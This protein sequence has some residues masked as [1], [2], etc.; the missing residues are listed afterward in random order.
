MCRYWF[1][2]VTLQNKPGT[3]RLQRSIGTAPH[4][5]IEVILHVMIVS[6]MTI[7]QGLLTALD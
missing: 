7:D 1:S 3:E 2:G 5:I 4:V 6:V